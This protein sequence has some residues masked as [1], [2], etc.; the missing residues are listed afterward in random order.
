MAPPPPPPPLATAVPSTSS[1]ITPSSFTSAPNHLPSPSRA[2][3]SPGVIADHG[4]PPP[5]AQLPAMGASSDLTPSVLPD[6]V[7]RAAAMAS[8]KDDLELA[9]R[10]GSGRPGPPLY[11]LQFVG[12]D[13]AVSS[14][15]A[16]TPCGEAQ[17]PPLS[18]MAVLIVDVV[19]SEDDDMGADVSPLRL[20]A[21]SP[22][23]ASTL[24]QN[25]APFPSGPGRSKARRWADEDIVDAP[26]SDTALISYLDALHRVPLPPRPLSW[27]VPP[28]QHTRHSSSGQLAWCRPPGWGL[29]RWEAASAASTAGAR[30]AHSAI[31]GRIPARQCLGRRGRRW[32]DRPRPQLVCGLPVWPVQGR[33]PCQRRRGRIF[34]PNADRWQE[35]LH[36]QHTGS[37]TSLVVSRTSQL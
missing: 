14:T 32:R 19:E 29:T 26:D 30:H 17:P 34:A 36:R 1:A 33:T 7:P 23:P 31:G 21:P 6:L 13:A 10:P 12:D 9:V 24:S 27:P 18:S 22:S 28:L 3:R 20:P 37:A 16:S 25:A 35:V 15:S 4:R 2:D 11:P 5:S 8:A